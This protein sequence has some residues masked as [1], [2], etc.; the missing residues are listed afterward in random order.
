MRR[1]PILSL[2]IS[3]I[4]VLASLLLPKS[5]HASTNRLYVSNVNDNDVSV[6]APASGNTIT[7]ISLGGGSTPVGEAAYGNHVYVADYGGHSVSVIDTTTNTVVTTISLGNNI[8][9]ERLSVSNDGKRLYAGDIGSAGTVSVID[10]ST[11]TVSRTLTGFSMP[12][13]MVE[14]LSGTRLYV[15]NQNCCSSNGYVSVLD[16]SNYSTITTIQV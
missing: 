10:T 3:V 8:Y 14:N 2:A 7:T 15:I 16:T 11:N 4:F 13:Y 6:I 1:L 5:A 9:P 12:Q